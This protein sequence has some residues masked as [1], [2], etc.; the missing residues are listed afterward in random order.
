MKQLGQN[1]QGNSLVLLR[2][3]ALA[4]DKNVVMATPVDTGRAR[5]N[6]QVQINGPAQGELEKEDP[7]GAVTIAMGQTVIMGVQHGQAIHIT[8]NLPYVVVLNDEGTS[9]Q[10]PAHFVEDAIKA[11]TAYVNNFKLLRNI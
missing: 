10:A 4:I 2:K 8:N 9:A 7:S 3:L 5:A 6:W 1:I 11:A